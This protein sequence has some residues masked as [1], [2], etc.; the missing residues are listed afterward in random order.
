MLTRRIDRALDA[1]HVCE[2]RVPEL[3]EIYPQGSPQALA[4]DAVMAS[5]DNAK[6]VLF[7][8]VGTKPK[9]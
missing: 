7:E 6:A 3:R 9:E 1:L 2:E 5:I 4:L 8:P